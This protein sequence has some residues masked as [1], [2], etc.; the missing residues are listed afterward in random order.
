M[1]EDNQGNLWLGTNNGLSRLHKRSMDFTNYTT[2]DGLPVGRFRKFAAKSAKGE[3]FMPI[4]NG[5]IAFYPDSIYSTPHNTPVVLTD[6]HLNNK[7]VTPEDASVLTKHITYTDRIDL[8]YK[9]NNLS[10]DLAILDYIRPH[11]NQYKYILEGFH[12]DWIYAGT[13]NF[14]DLNNLKPGAYTLKVKATNHEG[15]WTSNGVSLDIVIHPPPW[16]TWWAYVIYGL[17]L[18][19]T[20]LLVRRYLVHSARLRTAVEIERIERE[21]VEELDHLKSHFFANI[22]HEFRTPL[23]LLMG[24]INDL[25]KTQTKL[26]AADRKLLAIMKRNAGRLQQLINQ[27]LDLSRF[28]T[29]KVRLEIQKGD[30]SAWVGVISQSFLSLAESKEID[31]HHHISSLSDPV[32]YDKDKVE[33]ILTNLLSN[34]FKFTPKGGK[35]RVG[36]SYLYADSSFGPSHAE[37]SVQDTGEGIPGELM[38]KVFDRFYQIGYPGRGETAGTG[39]GL[40]LVKELVGIYRGEIKVD[41]QPGK[42]SRFIVVLPVSRS[43]FQEEEISSAQPSWPEEITGAK[44]TE[45]NKFAATETLSDPGIP[46]KEKRTERKE[47][48]P[49]IL[50]VEDNLD[51]RQYISRHLQQEYEIL[52]AEN[53]KEGMD[54]ARAYIPDLVIS[55]LMMSE[56]DGMEMFRRLRED[57]RTSH[58]PLIMLTSRADRESKLEGL[59]TGADEYITKPFDSEEVRIR[60]RNLIRQRERMQEQFNRAYFLENKNIRLQS[61]DERFL[62]KAKDI[63]EEHLSDPDFNVEKFSYQLGI[64]RMQLHRKCKGLANQSP[65]EFI[66]KLRLKHSCILLNVG[67][68]NIAQIAYQVGFSDPAYYARCFRRLY[69]LSPSEYQKNYRS[70]SFQTE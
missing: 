46:D 26:D 31:F 43:H 69:G 44:R 50:V 47:K 65:G 59:L 17:F 33:K 45:S 51:L 37:L 48:P 68:D 36:I 6:F 42:G 14:V 5:M 16:L 38:E 52:E 7:P 10:F 20:G 1:M 64:S 62:A 13:R 55:D 32:F 35:I 28:E 24:P 70:P 39:I 2:Q 34:A 29:G 63:L 11:L 15:V 12:K 66:Q 22:S 67:V 57:E 54:L 9:Q 60:I 30:L 19:G 25:L 58:I 40:S 3:I 8:G 27:L 41:S 61:A 49:L 18:L 56:M 21:K 23:T 4:E 53:G